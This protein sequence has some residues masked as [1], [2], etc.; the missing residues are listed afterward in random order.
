MTEKEVKFS[1]KYIATIGRR[2]QAIAQV[3]LYPKG[4]GTIIINGRAFEA[5]LPV[6]T[7]QIAA[8]SPLVET[9][10]E[11]EVDISVKVSGGGIAG[12]ADA[13]KLGIARALTEHNADFR[14]TLKK[15]GMLTRDPRV[16]ERKKFGKKSA[17]RSPQWSKR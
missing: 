9:G 15:A 12:Q 5:Y 8:K 10:M 16:R 6:D 4:K 14:T 11:K 2:K 1:G 13:I 17:R 7:L 3:R